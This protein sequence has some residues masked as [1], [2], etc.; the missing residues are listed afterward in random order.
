MVDYMIVNSTNSELTNVNAGGVDVP[1]RSVGNTITLT[2]AE[3]AAVVA[4]GG[5]VAVLKDNATRQQMREVARVLKYRKVRT[6]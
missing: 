2:D 5:G 3:L 6:L 1:A 4:L